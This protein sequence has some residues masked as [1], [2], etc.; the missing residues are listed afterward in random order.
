MGSLLGQFGRFTF[1][2]LLIGLS[3]SIALLKLATIFVDLLMLKVMK[4]TVDV[5]RAAQSIQSFLTSFLTACLAAPPAKILQTF[6]ICEHGGRA[7]S[8]GSVPT[9]T[10]AGSKESL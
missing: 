10:A 7:P 2:N 9:R 3:A 6:Q 4:K 8:S 1:L 5:S